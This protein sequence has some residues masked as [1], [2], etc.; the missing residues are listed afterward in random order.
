MNREIINKLSKDLHVLVLGLAKSG[1]SAAKLLRKYGVRVVVNERRPRVEVEDT[2]C[3][4]E[5]EG[6]QCVCGGHPID[7]LDGKFDFIVKNPGIPYTLPLLIEAGKRNIPVYTEI[8]IAS[9]VTDSLIYAITGSNGKTTTT[10]LVGEILEA[11]GREPVVAGNIGRALSGVVL[12]VGAN[13]PIVL[14]VSSFQLMGTSMFHPRIAALLNL[15]PAHLDYHGSMEAYADAK[16]RMFQNM[17]Q[18]DFAV[19]NY[20]QVAIRERENEISAH[21][22]WFSRK[23]TDILQGVC[24]VNGSITLVRESAHTPIM[25]VKDIALKGEHNLENAIAAA[26]VSI[27]AGASI[28]HVK[29]VLSRFRGVEHRTEY[30]ATI[31]QVEYYNDSKATNAEAALRALRSFPRNIIWIAGG[32]DRGDDFH[33]MADDIRAHVKAAILLGQSADKLTFACKENGIEQ[34]QRVA[35]IEEAVALAHKIALPMDTVLLS[36]ACA[37]WDMF[38]SFEERGRMFKDAVHRL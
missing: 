22:V 10:T 33:T 4:L 25:D 28:E 8:E 36:P 16:W 3:N 13:S 7:L 21:V 34:V 27:W 23:S 32:L 31:Q 15:Y 6:I 11:A 2:V 30:V 18:G 17:N 9:W 38:H 29:F 5:I 12:Q 1:E 20:D 35:T 24:V 26:A 14:E 37:S 19:L